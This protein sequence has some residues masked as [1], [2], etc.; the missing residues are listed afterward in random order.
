V[1]L[2]R[3]HDADFC[4]SG[5]AAWHTRVVALLPTPVNLTVEWLGS[6]A[7]VGGISGKPSE[8]L[9]PAY[10]VA[11][12]SKWKGGAA[13][14]SA[15]S[16]VRFVTTDSHSFVGCVCEPV[17]FNCGRLRILVAS[18]GRPRKFGLS[19][20]LAPSSIQNASI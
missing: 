5:V 16:S 18:D 10:I 8:Y 13:R 14:P 12:N 6:D 7:S 4:T 17:G 20:P 3:G 9:V 11:E 19:I 15:L 1:E 2:K